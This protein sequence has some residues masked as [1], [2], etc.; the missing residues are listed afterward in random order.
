MKFTQTVK[1]NIYTRDFTEKLHNA[2]KAALKDVVIDIANDSIRDSPFKTGNNRRSIAYQ[3]EGMA[4]GVKASEGIPT[5]GVGV[6]EN[7]AAVYSTSG[8]GGYLETGTRFMGGRPY[9]KPAA[10]R[11]FTEEKVGNLIKKHLGDS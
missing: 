1:T 9:M 7:Q 4:S 10:D 5:E 2:A 8:Y 6:G 11:N 3:V